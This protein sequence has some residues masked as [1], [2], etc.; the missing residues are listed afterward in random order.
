[1]YT[2]VFTTVH[3]LTITSAATSNRRHNHGSV[4]IF[5]SP[6]VPADRLSERSRFQALYAPSQFRDA[7][8]RA[9]ALNKRALAMT[10][11]FGITKSF[12]L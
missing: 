7:G 3:Y 5:D 2:G 9:R 11:A 4:P 6:D 8:L 1:V 10:T 12:D